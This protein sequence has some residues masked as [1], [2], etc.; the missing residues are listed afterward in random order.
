MT[1]PATA[2]TTVSAGKRW[3]ILVPA[4]VVLIA[5]IIAIGLYLRS[6][7]QKAP[8]TEKDTI[9]LADFTNT[10]GD[11]VFDDALKQALAV[12][13]G[14]SPFLNVLSDRKGFQTTLPLRC[15]GCAAGSPS[16]LR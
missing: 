9:I 6:R 8:L 14:Q 7:S 16:T 5:A 11:A 1:V 12:E 13:L 2:A 3:K 10:T 4:A 15:R